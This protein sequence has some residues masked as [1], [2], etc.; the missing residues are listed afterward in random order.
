MACPVLVGLLMEKSGQCRS[1][2]KHLGDIQVEILGRQSDMSLELRKE[3]LGVA[4]IEMVSKIT[5]MA[6][7]AGAEYKG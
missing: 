1:V 7:M 5:G 2:F 6:E 4:S 3:S